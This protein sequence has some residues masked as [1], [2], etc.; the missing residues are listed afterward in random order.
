[1]TKNPGPV[2]KSASNYHVNLLAP[3]PRYWRIPSGGAYLAKPPSSLGGE[4]GRTP[5]AEFLALS[6]RDFRLTDV[7]GKVVPDLIA[8]GLDLRGTNSN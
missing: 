3:S 5:V 4:I 8:Q 1:M 7:H 2:I 6:G